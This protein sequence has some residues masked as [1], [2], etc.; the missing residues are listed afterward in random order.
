MSPQI[1]TG[2]R[3][4]MNNPSENTN[5]TLIVDLDVHDSTSVVDEVNSAGQNTNVVETLPF[6]SM[7]VSAPESELEQLCDL[8]VINSIE[9]EGEGRVLDS[10]NLQFLNG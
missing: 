8:S 4:R 10:G 7:V 5:V 3:D 6:G 9:I 1:E 2:V